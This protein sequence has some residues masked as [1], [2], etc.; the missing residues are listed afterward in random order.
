M[1]SKLILITIS[2]VLFLTWTNVK[3]QT[4]SLNFS[5][6]HLQA[7]ENLLISMGLNTQFGAIT[8]N[9][10][11]A[12]GNQ[13]PENNRAAFV[14]VMQKF[15][16]KYYNWE[17]LKGDFSKIYAAEFSEGELVQMTAFFNTPVGKKYAN[18]LALLTQ[19][20]MLLGQKV[21]Q[22]HQTELEQMMKNA[23]PEKN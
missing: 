3:A 16:N 10:V 21:V 6:S 11:K 15:M 17:V 18:K 12:F 14:G 7:A 13:M 5:P 22:D 9:I 4:A 8:D 20:G 2:C 19:K 23:I 1:K